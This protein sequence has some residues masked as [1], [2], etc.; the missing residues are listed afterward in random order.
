MRMG[1][2]LVIEYEKRDHFAVKLIMHKVLQTLSIV[3]KYAF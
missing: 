1:L 3:H 2:R